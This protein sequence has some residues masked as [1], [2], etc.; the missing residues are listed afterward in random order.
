MDPMGY[1]FLMVSY[2]TDAPAK[3][4]P[5]DA[6]WPA[7]PEAAMQRLEVPNIQH[8]IH[9]L[10]TQLNQTGLNPPQTPQYLGLSICCMSSSLQNLP[11]Q[12]NDTDTT[13]ATH[14]HQNVSV[15]RQIPP[16]PGEGGEASGKNT[17]MLVDWRHILH[18]KI[19]NT[20]VSYC[21]SVSLVTSPSCLYK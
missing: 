14:G 9:Q 2:A 6:S 11:G 17:K 18:T 13:H 3:R 20:T 15:A 10:Y 7:K 8:D 21:F 4:H 1:V 5:V 19:A 16:E 12:H